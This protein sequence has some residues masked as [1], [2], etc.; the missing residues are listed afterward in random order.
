MLFAFS[1]QLKAQTIR[2]YTLEV[3]C[4]SR[5]YN[6]SYSILEIKWRNRSP[7][8]SAI[9]VYRKSKTAI[10]WGSVNA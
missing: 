8:A 2:N 5:Y 7:S 6:S 9:N 3:S 4:K 10:T 1:N